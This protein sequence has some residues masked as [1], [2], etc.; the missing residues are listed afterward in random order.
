MD[1]AAAT[2]ARSG[3]MFAGLAL[4]L[5]ACVVGTPAAS[6]SPS[7]ALSAAPSATPAAPTTRQVGDGDNGRSVSVPVGATVSLVLASTY[8]QV[9]GS[10]DGAVLTL[11]MG[12]TAS[13]AAVGACVPGAGCGT[14]T[15]V[16]RAVAPGSATITAARTTCGEALR[17][18]GSAG[19]YLLTIVVGG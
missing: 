9:Q 7:A 1:R 10:S 13:A 19:A 5:S 4:L 16:F 12:P 15:T 6:A 8:W 17:C 11:V 18:T 14:V 2:R 3:A